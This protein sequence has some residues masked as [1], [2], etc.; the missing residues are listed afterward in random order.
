MAGI[1]GRFHSDLSGE[2]SLAFAHLAEGSPG[3]AL[4][5]VDE[6]GLAL[7]RDMGELLNRLPDLD[8]VLLHR[9]AEKAARGGADGPFR[10]STEIIGRW[11]RRL[12]GGAATGRIDAAGVTET[13]AADLARLAPAADAGRWLDA[14]E[15]IEALF[16]R[17]EAV[18]LDRK[19]ALLD[20]FFLLRAAARG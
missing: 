2:E 18:N 19:A 9:F 8:G 17:T 5:L 7:H 14:R 11:V 13:E 12:A 16:E 20:A 1:L 10:T 3:R 4:E 6:D 15:K